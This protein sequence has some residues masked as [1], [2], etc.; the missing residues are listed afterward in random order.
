MCRIT[1]Y[2]NE[3]PLAPK[4]GA[5]GAADVQRGADVVE[6]AEADLL[7]AQGAGVLAAAEVDR[8]QDTLDVFEVHLGQLGLSQ[9][10]TADRACRTGRAPRHT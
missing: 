8:E 7:G 4:D 2:S 10:E 3:I 1:G 9:L 6:L 5:C